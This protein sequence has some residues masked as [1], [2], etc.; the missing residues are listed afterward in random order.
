M[1][2]WVARDQIEMGLRQRRVALSTPWMVIVVSAQSFSFPF[3]TD[4]QTYIHAHNPI[5]HI[6]DM[7]HQRIMQKL[8][9]VTNILLE[10]MIPS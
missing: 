3:Q 1:A 5:G 10:L 7:E 8:I 6:L 2:S 9:K 4:Y